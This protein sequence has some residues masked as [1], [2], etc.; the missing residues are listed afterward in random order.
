MTWTLGMIQ[1]KSTNFD[2]WI[3]HSSQHTCFHQHQSESFEVSWNQ[4]KLRWTWL[5]LI[6]SS[7]SFVGKEEQAAAKDWEDVRGWWM[8]N[9]LLPQCWYCWERGKDSSHVNH[10]I[11]VCWK[12]EPLWLYIW[13]K[14][15]HMMNVRFQVYWK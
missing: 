9:Q 3:L 4:T 5:V 14:F 8:V 7:R 10:G 6:D 11:E 12:P 15:C 2:T 13:T 1:V